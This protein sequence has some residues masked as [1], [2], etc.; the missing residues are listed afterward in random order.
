MPQFC[1]LPLS[2]VCRLQYGLKFWIFASKITYT[3][4]NVEVCYRY[5]PKH[6]IQVFDVFIIGIWICNE[7]IHVVR[8]KACRIRSENKLQSPYKTGQK[9]RKPKRTLLSW[10]V[11]PSK[12]NAVHIREDSSNAICR[13]ALF[14]SIEEINFAPWILCNS[15]WAVD[16]SLCLV[17]SVC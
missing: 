7:I 5:F 6:C 16:F 14:K 17:P 9:L 15:S 2:L 11:W 4:V 13:K 8:N 1:P 3:N 10:Y 12:W